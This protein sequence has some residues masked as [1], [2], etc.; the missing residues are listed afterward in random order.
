MFMGNPLLRAA[1]EK[2][3]MSQYEIEEYVKCKNDII[4]FAENYFYIKTNGTKSIVKLYDYQKKILKACVCPP[5]GKQHLCQLLSRQMGKSLVASIYLTHQAIF[6]KEGEIIILANKEA[7]AKD[8]LEKIKLAFMNLPLWL[9]KG[10]VS[11]GWN[12]NSVNLENGIKITAASSSSDS[13]RG[14]S[15]FLVYIDEA[16]FV[17]EHIWPEFWNSVYSIIS[18]IKDPRIILTSTPKGMNHFY[19]I[20]T[21]AVRG[22]NNFYPIKVTWRGH[23]DR[24]D[25]WA[26][27]TRKDMGDERAFQQEHECSFLGSSNTL[28]EPN[29]LENIETKKPIEYKYNGAMCIYEQP[30]EKCQYVVGC[31]PA[32]GG[33]GDSSTVQVLR[34]DSKESVEQVAIFS[35]EFTDPESFADICVG[36]A[37]FYNDAPMMVENNDIGTIVCNRIWNELYYENM[38]NLDPKGLGIRANRKTKLAGNL[39]LKKYIDNKFLKINDN[40]TLFEL[41]RYVEHQPGVFHCASD[42]DH[43]DTVT[44]TIWALVYLTSDFFDEVS[45]EFSNKSQKDTNKYSEEDRPMLFTNSDTTSYNPYNNYPEYYNNDSNNSQNYSW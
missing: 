37:K 19:E 30:K 35:N 23:P 39:L 36:I 18:S 27:K 38:I 41:S 16:S 29:I 40:K 1:G 4:H 6:R 15:S 8:I 42:S 14:R 45:N 22:E 34:I 12:K 26:E 24:D 3:T 20:Y 43:D 21:K 2:I 32:R 28:I 31:D 13:V 44:S 5:E 11:G 17:P 7:T 9:Q 33:G 25:A 10:V